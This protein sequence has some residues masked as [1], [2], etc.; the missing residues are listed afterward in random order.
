MAT[1]CLCPAVVLLANKKHHPTQQRQS[2]VRLAIVL[3]GCLSPGEKC[4]KIASKQSGAWG[5]VST[6]V[7]ATCGSITW[8]LRGVK[9]Q[10][11][12]WLKT[13][14]NLALDQKPS[15]LMGRPL[16]VHHIDGPLASPAVPELSLWSRKRDEK[17]T[18]AQQYY[19]FRRNALE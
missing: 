14:K 5:S 19:L 13:K 3:P 12:S 17:S 11:L 6:N 8:S 1:K 16:S 10:S 7:L 2:F 4:T 18:K 15:Q 9:C